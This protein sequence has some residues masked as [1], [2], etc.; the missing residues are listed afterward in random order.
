MAQITLTREE[1]K[2][3]YDFCRENG[4]KTYF[5]AKDQGAYLGASAG[6]GK[7]VIFYFQGCNPDKDE[8]WYDNAMAK[9]GGDDFG[10]MLD[11]AELKKMLDAGAIKVRWEISSTQIK[12]NFLRPSKAH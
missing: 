6:K 7:N 8:D 2:K 5:I 9:F 1:I 3:L 11:P 12:M 4:L 10:E